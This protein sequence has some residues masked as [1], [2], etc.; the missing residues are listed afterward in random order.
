MRG[1]NTPAYFV[2]EEKKIVL[3]HDACQNFSNL[4]YEKMP[5]REREREQGT[6]TEREGSVQ[7]NSSLRQVAL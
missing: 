5:E 7:L 3:E 1:T 2:F 6:L 4:L